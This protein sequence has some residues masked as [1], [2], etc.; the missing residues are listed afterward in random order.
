PFVALNCGALPAEMIESELF[1]HE[2]G[3]FTGAVRQRVGKLESARGG[4]VLLDEI[5]SM[6]VAL[7]V[8]LLRVIET[9]S[10]ERL[11]SNKPI[12]LDVRFIAATKSDLGAQSEAG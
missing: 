7:Q 5:E 6:P 4:T 2:Q 1:G 10:I 9:R 11:G 8:K 3:A 12:A